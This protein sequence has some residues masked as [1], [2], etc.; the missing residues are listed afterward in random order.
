MLCCAVKIRPVGTFTARFRKRH[1]DC[2]GITKQNLVGVAAGLAHVG[3]RP[4]VLAWPGCHR[5]TVRRSKA[6]T[7]SR[8]FRR[9]MCS[10]HASAARSGG[11]RPGPSLCPWHRAGLGCGRGPGLGEEWRE[12]VRHRVTPTRR[13]R[14]A[15]PA[16]RR[17]PSLRRPPCRARPGPQRQQDALG[18]AA[19][20]LAILTVLIR[21]IYS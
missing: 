19:F 16:A 15:V 2:F 3:L 13:R 8:E 21:S 12:H 10:C 14:A 11:A 6:T 4:F 5:P 20:L 7:P 1:F 9:L 17:P 18:V